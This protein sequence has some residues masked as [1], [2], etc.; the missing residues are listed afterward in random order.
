MIVCVTSI[1][2]IESDGQISLL[3]HAPGLINKAEPLTEFSTQAGRQAT[4]ESKPA[5]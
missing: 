3:L 2:F 1:L 4:E 5:E